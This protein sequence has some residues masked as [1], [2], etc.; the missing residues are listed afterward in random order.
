METKFDDGTTVVRKN[1]V[2]VTGIIWWMVPPIASAERRR[3]R[4][5]QRL[6]GGVTG[7]DQRDVFFG[8]TE[9][10]PPEPERVEDFGRQDLA[11]ASCRLAAETISRISGPQ[12]RAW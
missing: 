7:C 2:F 10:G 4:R 6:A 5:R 9:V 3:D 1:S 8:D 11:N 12:V